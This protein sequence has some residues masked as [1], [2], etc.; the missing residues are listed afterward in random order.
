MSKIA[1]FFSFFNFFL[2]LSLYGHTSGSENIAKLRL[3][4]FLCKICIAMNVFNPQHDY[5]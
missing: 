2:G 3:S 1:H 5:R 4:T